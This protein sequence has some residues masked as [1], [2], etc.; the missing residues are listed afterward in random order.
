MEVEFPIVV[1]FKAK[2]DFESKAEKSHGTRVHNALMLL[3]NYE[4]NTTLWMDFNGICRNP[5]VFMIVMIREI[6]R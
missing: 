3:L 1:Y 5:I 4:N 6:V 2:A